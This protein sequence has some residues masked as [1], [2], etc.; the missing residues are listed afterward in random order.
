MATKRWSD[1]DQAALDQALATGRLPD[2]DNRIA[3][4]ARLAQFLGF[5]RQ[6]I[7]SHLGGRR[8]PLH[9]VLKR[10]GGSRG[11]FSKAHRQALARTATIKA[12]T[13]R[14]SLH[15]FGRLNF[16]LV[17]GIDEAQAYARKKGARTRA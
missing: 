6:T 13:G 15:R 4:Q 7:A 5:S 2:P 10:E 16:D 3:T 17:D 14:L 1:R 12:R 9:A 11:G 8:L